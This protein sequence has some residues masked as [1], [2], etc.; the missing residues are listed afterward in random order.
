MEDQNVC[1]QPIETL[2]NNNSEVAVETVW[3]T[4]C[5]RL[6]DD[7][8]EQNVRLMKNSNDSGKGEGGWRMIP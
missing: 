5:V 3:P 1:M 4:E 6:N 8:E 7:W 2:K